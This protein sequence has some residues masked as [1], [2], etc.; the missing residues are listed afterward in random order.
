MGRSH[1]AKVYPRG[2]VL[3]FR[4]PHS[5]HQPRFIAVVR[6][7]EGKLYHG[8]MTRAQALQH[9]PYLIE[10]VNGFGQVTHRENFERIARAEATIEAVTGLLAGAQP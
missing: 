10:H 8:C 3:W 2:R 4:K 5:P 6:T 1:F 7:V 9:K